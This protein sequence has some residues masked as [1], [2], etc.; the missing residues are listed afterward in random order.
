MKTIIIA[1]ALISVGV[2]GWFYWS[3]QKR[4]NEFDRIKAELTSVEEET[5]KLGDPNI[6]RFSDSDMYL[7]KHQVENTF[8][9]REIQQMEE[10]KKL[11]L[12]SPQ[13]LERLKA[14]K[15]ELER[16]LNG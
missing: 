13:E 4:S 9:R 3:Y 7:L 6:L 14:K 2:T 11:L 15:D 10:E 8:Y 16:E 5:S 12:N 1:S